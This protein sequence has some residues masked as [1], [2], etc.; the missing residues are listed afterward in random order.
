M[1]KDN[2][3]FLYLG[4]FFPIFSNVAAGGGVIAR[5]VKWSYTNRSE[6]ASMKKLIFFVLLCAQFPYSAPAEQP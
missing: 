2:P 5:A 4:F 3:T 1:F 6:I